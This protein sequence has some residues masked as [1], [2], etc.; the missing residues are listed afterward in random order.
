LVVILRGERGWGVGVCVWHGGWWLGWVRG[1]L[2]SGLQ[3]ESGGSAKVQSGL[4]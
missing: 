4:F 3:A 1:A 2:E